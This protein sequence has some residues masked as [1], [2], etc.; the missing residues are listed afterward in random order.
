MLPAK[1]RGAIPGWLLPVFASIFLLLAGSGIWLYQHEKARALIAAAEQLEAVATLLNSQIVN[2]RQERYA[3]GQTLSESS[4]LISE[5]ARVI[6]NDPAAKTSAVLDRLRSFSNN[7]R[8]HDAL[9]LD[10]DNR[11]LLS[12]SGRTKPLSGGIYNEIKEAGVIRKPV[13][14]DIHRSPESGK[15]HMDVVIPLYTSKAENARQIGSVLLQIDLD[16]FL[17][18]T[19]QK[20]PLPSQTAEALLIRKD[21]NDVLFLNELRFRKDSA[22]NMR[23]ASSESDVPTVMAIFGDKHGIVEGKGYDG[24]PVLAYITRV[25]ESN[26][27]LITKVSRVEALATWHFASYLIIAVTIGLLLAAAG[28]FGFIYQSHGLQRYKS[29]YAAEEAAREL[30]ERFMLAFQASPI[31]TSIATTSDGRLVDINSQFERDFGWSKDELIGHTSTEIGLWPD[32]DIRNE[33]IARLKKMKSVINE[34]ALWLDS[35][36]KPH[37]VEISAAIFELN[38]VEHVLAFI[39]DVTQ[40]RRNELE[41]SKYQRRLELMV[42]ERTSELMLAKELAEQASR[43]KSSFLAN[44]SH[45]IRTP[46]NAVIGLTHLMQR[47]ATERRLKERLGQVHDSAQHLLAV[48]NDILDISKIEAGKLT[49]EEVAVDIPEILK[50]VVTLLDDRI[51]SRG[52]VLLIETD[53]FPNLFLGDPTRISQSLINYTSNAIKFT[54]SGSITLR[55]KRLSED[56]T[57]ATLRFEVEDTGIGIAPEVI[58][59]LFDSFKQADSSM[60]RKYGGTGLGLAITRHLAQA[61]GGDAGV[62]SQPGRGSCFWFTVCLKKNTA[63]SPSTVTVQNEPINLELLAGHHV[64]IVEDEP[65]NREIAIDLLSDVGVSC[66]YAEN[67]RE[68]VEL[69]SRNHYDLILMDMQMPEMDGLEATRQIRQLSGCATLPIVA[70]TANAF[71]EDRE[72]CRVAG[73][74]DFMAKPIDPD[75]LFATLLHNLPKTRQ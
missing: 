60:T 40:K 2:W 30:R 31:A 56:D 64:L 74:T 25:P 3:D 67:G 63:F 13:I 35:A 23:I 47:E 42:D 34:D 8:Y 70:M 24:T 55:A 33:W 12:A 61:M 65:I 58:A 51:R 16:A 21:G 27:S 50:G 9:L 1:T 73:M 28:I 57:T 39:A 69:V 18:P 46:L 14:S 45:E 36:G 29:L 72:R 71:T 11:I 54:D 7:Y 37:N 53:T 5:I 62:N 20:W 49:L 38:G 66:D 48:I 44:M 32:S 10:L 68:A 41:L 26:W 6:S 15:P 43:A 19:L 75:V 59:S 52:L 17:Y 22:L 4:G